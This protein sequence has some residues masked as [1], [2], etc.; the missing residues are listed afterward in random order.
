MANLSTLLL[1][2]VA[3]LLH[4]CVIFHLPQVCAKGMVSFNTKSCEF[5]RGSVEPAIIGFWGPI[6]YESVEKV[7]HFKSYH[8]NNDDNRFTK[9]Y[10]KIETYLQMAFGQSIDPTFIFVGTWKTAEA[11]V[12]ILF[13][14]SCR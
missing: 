2:V 7:Y 14:I 4:W 11:E 8:D 12:S 10:F 5:E 1:L 6:D 3:I 9:R 13:F